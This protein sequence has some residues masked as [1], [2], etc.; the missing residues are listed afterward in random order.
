MKIKPAAVADPWWRTDMTKIACA[1]HICF[2]NPLTETYIL[3]SVT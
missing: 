2:V 3:E 1:F